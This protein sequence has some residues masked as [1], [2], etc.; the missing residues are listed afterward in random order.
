MPLLALEL[1]PVPI[2]PEHGPT[3]KPEEWMDFAGR[4]VS[5]LGGL[6]QTLEQGVE[7]FVSTTASIATGIIQ[8]DHIQAGTI[9]ASLISSTG[10]VI[11]Q[12]AQI[13]DA[14]ITNAKVVSVESQKVYI[15][16]NTSQTLTTAG[17]TLILPGLIQISGG[18]ASVVSIKA[19]GTAF[20]TRDSSSRSLLI[21]GIE[22]ITGNNST[23]GGATNTTR[24]IAISVIDTAGNLLGGTAGLFAYDTFGSTAAQDALASHINSVSPSHLVVLTSYD[25]IGTGVVS[26]D[27]GNALSSLGI[28][29]LSLEG[30][31]AT[32]G[33][34]GQASRI[35]F[36]GLGHRGA[37]AGAGVTVFT[38]GST[39][40][41]AAVFNDFLVG[42]DPASGSSPQFSNVTII[43]GGK[44]RADSIT[45]V[46]IAA[47]AITS[48][49]LAA[50]AVT[51]GKIAAGTITATELAASAV[52]S[53]KIAAGAVTA[54]KIAAG[55]ITT[56]ELAASAVTSTNI[57]AGAVTAGKI[58]A[59]TVTATELAASAVTSTKIA[60]GAVVAGKIAAGAITA[61]GAEI[62][63]AAITTAKIQDAQI[64][65]AKIA[66]NAVS[67]HA[68]DTT[69]NVSSLSS[70]YQDVLSV[71]ITVQQTND[72]V[73]IQANIQATIS[74][75]E[76][77]DKTSWKIT[78]DGITIKEWANLGNATAATNSTVGG[79][80]FAVR[81]V[82]M[83]T[84]VHTYAL[85]G[86]MTDADAGGELAVTLN[87]G[88][89]L[90]QD[91][92]GSA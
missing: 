84:G 81:D 56:T 21:N 12:E 72:L 44:I 13:A 62:A 54:G 63:D 58:A 64:T 88:F 67:T 16:G 55:T 36:V 49:E 30:V 71:P 91:F 15:T 48:T 27:L 40:A 53:A 73:V 10:A 11:T 57:A 83:T 19:K 5:W 77:G 52:T 18:G 3:E 26:G 50:G 6:Q 32:G 45:A 29:V 76:P 61:T 7:A 22:K 23:A 43:E 90:V 28:D 35:P 70:V 82:G 89:L 33:N 42:S 66:G 1:P 85:A 65:R 24:G 51:A 4:V 74:G 87:S 86:M 60:A 17:S 46:Q 25:S 41:G 31:F 80:I 92:F 34:S 59:G 14:I 39:D 69:L 79:T 2:V 38:N 78:R 8:A 68:V 47:S 37:G 20:G 9:V 75:S